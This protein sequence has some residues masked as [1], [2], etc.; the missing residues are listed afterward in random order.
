MNEE[1]K[2]TALDRMTGFTN[3]DGSITLL[4]DIKLARARKLQYENIELPF[5][6]MPDDPDTWTYTRG[7][8]NDAQEGD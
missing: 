1:I 2:I 7:E 8:A 3:A 5:E 6:A 4:S